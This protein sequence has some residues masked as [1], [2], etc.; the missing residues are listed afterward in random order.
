MKP[1]DWVISLINDIY[2]VGMK[3]ILLDREDVPCI[4]KKKM[5][6]TYC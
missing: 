2:K 1:E 5:K 4:M 6:Y 3:Y